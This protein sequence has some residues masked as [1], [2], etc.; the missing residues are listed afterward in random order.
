MVFSIFCSIV[1]DVMAKK[2]FNESGILSS[3]DK[4]G[5]EVQK[6]AFIQINNK[7]SYSELAYAGRLLLVFFFWAGED[8]KEGQYYY[9]DVI[10]DVI[11]N[12][13][14]KRKEL[15]NVQSK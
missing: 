10:K 9:K 12:I 7:I 14:L 3:N 1:L 15:K 6:V 4:Q 2:V 5:T 11:S 13:V 8:Q